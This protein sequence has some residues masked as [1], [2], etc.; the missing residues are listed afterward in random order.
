MKT[1]AEKADRHVL[2]QKSVQDP[3]G[4]AEL[5]QEKFQEIRGREAMSFREDFCGTAILSVA[6]C[7]SDESRTA[8]GIDLCE[9]TLRVQ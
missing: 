6:W 2:Y 9:E 5:I 7:Q 8:Q 4:D 3:E 1:M